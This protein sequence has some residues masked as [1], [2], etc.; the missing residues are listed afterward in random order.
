MS[1]TLVTRSPRHTGG[2]PRLVAPALVTRTGNT[3]GRPRLVSSTL[4]ARP[5]PATRF[6]HPPTLW[7]RAGDDT[8]LRRHTPATQTSIRAYS[9]RRPTGA[10]LSSMP[11]L[12]T[13]PYSLWLPHQPLESLSRN[14]GRQVR[15]SCTMALPV[16]W[17]LSR[18]QYY[19]SSP[20][21]GEATRDAG[22]RA[23]RRGPRAARVNQNWFHY[24]TAYRY[25]VS[26]LTRLLPSQVQ[27]PA[28]QCRPAQAPPAAARY[29]RSRGYCLATF[30]TRPSNDKFQAGRHHP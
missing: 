21:G 15:G 14:C 25:A 22:G 24:C 19:P 2:C 4:V 18:R 29:P 5:Q 17:C 23:G 8:A 10:C 30:P 6:P 26:S 1:T 27:T 28:S 12:L 9:S 11:M 13:L 20:P 7:H 3:G 16:P